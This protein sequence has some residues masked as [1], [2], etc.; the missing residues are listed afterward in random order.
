MLD[1]FKLER[2][3]SAPINTKHLDPKNKNKTFA[4]NFQVKIHS[5]LG[6]NTVLQI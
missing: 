2:Q 1:I 5:Q 4:P 6:L 3:G